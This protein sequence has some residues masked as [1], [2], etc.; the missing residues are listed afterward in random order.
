MTHVQTATA[1]VPSSRPEPSREPEIRRLPARNPG[2]GL[3]PVHL[4][5]A[6]VAAMPFLIGIPRGAVL[7]VLRPSE[8]LQ[9]V[10]TVGG[11]AAVA[12]AMIGGRRWRLQLR[13]LEWWLLAT[14]VSASVVPLLWLLARARPVGQAELLAAFPFVKY[15]ILYLLVRFGVRTGTEVAAVAKAT[16]IAALIVAAIA[17]T[18]ALGVGPVIDVLERFFVSSA[19]DVVDGG[20]GTTTIGSSIATGAYL[21][22]SCGLA[23]SY[24]LAS[25]RHLWLA[26]AGFLAVGALASGQAGTVLGLGIV[27]FTVAHL[28]RRSAQLLAWGIPVGVVGVFAL[29]PIVAARLDDL[30]RGSGLPSSW[31]IRW[32]NI[33]E[34][35][36]PSLMDRGWILGVSPDAVVTPP[37]VWRQTVYLESGYLWLLWV[38]GVP[39][40]IAA[41]GFLISAWRALDPD[42]SRQTSAAIDRSVA[43]SGAGSAT[44]FD[45]IAAV[46]IA[47]R[48]AVAMVAILSIIDPHL[49]LRAGAD[50]LFILLPLGLVS[51][52]A[53]VPIA[54][55]SL[56]WRR[57]LGPIGPYR[58]ARLQLAEGPS[59]PA[60]IGGAK[61][62]MTLDLTARHHGVD[63]ATA[64]LA[65]IRGRDGLRGVLVGPVKGVDEEARALAWRAVALSARSLRLTELDLGGDPMWGG[66]RIERAELKLAGRLAEKLEVERATHHRRADRA[67]TIG[68]TNGSQPGPE[69]DDHL[70][71]IRFDLG[72]RTPWWKRAIDLGIGLPTMVATAPLWLVA[73]LLVRRSSDGPV[74]YRQVR[75]GGGGLPFQIYKFR[76]MYL[77]TDDSAHR[78]QNRLELRGEAD[79]VKDEADPRITPIGR[80]L[81]RLSLDELPQLI[82]VLRSEMSLVGPRP[83][84]VWESEL[85]QPS[86]RRRLVARP[87]LT[88]FWQTSG[89]ADLSMAEMLVLD[90][91]YVDQHSPLVDIRCLAKTASSVLAGRGAR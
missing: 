22:I 44:P 90:L 45:P 60:A 18:Q 58:S 52:T 6:Y 29:W 87:G 26:A 16:V 54:T 70:P 8:A 79:A 84:L 24:G 25:R 40:L 33:S 50:L 76:T 31:L 61:P 34:L 14:A 85:F 39:L 67:T 42:R 43:A 57:Q 47:A 9:L 28:H 4:I 37:D 10:V 21:A 71:A 12:T 46:A 41:L 49:T 23:L 89:R 1:A 38:G 83:S 59:V 65:L 32:N 27:T 68:R 82:N 17:I 20:R 51:S 75:I 13:P 35:Y 3:A 78:V 64:R 81:R 73:A 19:E 53:A 48:A 11:V 63:I 62:E 72:G 74:L 80:L 77:D 91:D 2:L 36:L 88:G 15:V 5:V 69:E 56:R 66:E 7:A 86:M 55:S 30:D